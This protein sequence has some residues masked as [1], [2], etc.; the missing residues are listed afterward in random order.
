MAGEYS[1]LI[2]SGRGYSSRVP[3]YNDGAPYAVPASIQGA[4]EK[5]HEAA[6]SHYD[7]MNSNSDEATNG[8]YQ[9]LS[10][11]L[12]E[13]ESEISQLEQEI[14]R[15]KTL[16][17]L[18]ISKDPYWEIAK[19]RYIRTGDM[20]ELNNIV[21]RKMTKEMM[22]LQ[23][24]DANSAKAEAEERD[25]AR[26]DL[27]TKTQA[28]EAAKELFP[29]M[30]A[31]IVNA[32]RDPNDPV[33]VG[34]A[35]AAIVRYNNLMKKTGTEEEIELL[36]MPDAVA[37]PEFNDLKSK[38]SALGSNAQNIN[39]SNLKSFKD[40]LD[41]FLD[42]AKAKKNSGQITEVEYNSLV[43]EVNGY[44]NTADSSAQGKRNDAQ[45]QSDRA[46]A[47]AKEDAEKAK[48]NAKKSAE[49]DLENYRAEYNSNP[50]EA[51]R[52]FKAAHPGYKLGK[53][54]GKLIVMEDK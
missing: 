35:N 7:L 44:K 49:A 15:Q 36:P 10:Q 1:G 25:K 27:L 43:V 24:A 18:E 39:S 33:A 9:E 32:K 30:Q 50:K 6:S 42:S 40:S 2:S 31:K 34:D 20:G 51:I 16:K 14:A 45:G 53:D 5:A 13:V 46:K 37:N 52:K 21:N 47:K 22:E 23:K 48:E 28:E 38:L 4:N 8:R 12:K 29:I 11:R 41:K 54:G 3:N 26:A 17:S 19:E